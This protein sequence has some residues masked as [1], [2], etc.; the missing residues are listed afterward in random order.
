MSREM[1][2]SELKT[3]VAELKLAGLEENEVLQIVE[4]AYQEEKA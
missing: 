3:L 4:G 1:S 2:L